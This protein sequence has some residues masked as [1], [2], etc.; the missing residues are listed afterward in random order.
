MF[1]WQD[2]ER[3]IID[4]KNKIDCGDDGAHFTTLMLDIGKTL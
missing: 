4:F 2:T 1:R 3:I